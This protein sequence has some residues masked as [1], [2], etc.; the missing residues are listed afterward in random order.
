MNFFSNSQAMLIIVRLI[1]NQRVFILDFK[2]RRENLI[3]FQKN[4]KYD[5]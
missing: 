2:L 5:F 4:E 1:C 3:L